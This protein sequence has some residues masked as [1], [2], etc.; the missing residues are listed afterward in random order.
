ML[1]SFLYHKWEWSQL[2]LRTVRYAT[3]VIIHWMI[4]HNHILPWNLDFERWI[5]RRVPFPSNPWWYPP[6]WITPW[7]QYKWEY[8]HAISFSHPSPSQSF[9]PSRNSMC[10]TNRCNRG[11]WPPIAIPA[12]PPP[13]PTAPVV[14]LGFVLPRHPSIRWDPFRQW[15]NAAVVISFWWRQCW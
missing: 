4:H 9:R 14:I 11:A 1:H 7:V 15:S 12:L 8:S 3:I 10:T 5:R 6:H 13:R 2:V